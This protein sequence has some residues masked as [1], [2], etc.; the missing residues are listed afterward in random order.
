[1]RAR[2][3]RRNSASSV[4]RSIPP[5]WALPTARCLVPPDLRSRPTRVEGST[6]P[7][8]A[9]GPLWSV[10]LH[11][12]ENLMQLNGSTALVTGANR[13]LGRATV[14]ALLTAGVSKVHAA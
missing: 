6:G 5:V 7:H 13:G 4:R 11:P 12:K 14:E 8:P 2:R 9:R 3:D 1:M 10:N